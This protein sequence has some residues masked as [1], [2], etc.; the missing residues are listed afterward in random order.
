MKCSSCGAE[1]KE[2]AEFCVVCGKPLPKR[3]KC[4]KCGTEVLEGVMFCTN[5]GNRFEQKPEPDVYYEEEETSNPWKWVAVAL[6]A[7]LL[8]G[9]GAYWYFYMMPKNTSSDASTETADTTTQVISDAADANYAEAQEIEEDYEE[10]GDADVEEQEEEYDSD[11]ETPS[12]LESKQAD[13]PDPSNGEWW[14]GSI[15]KY[16]IRMYINEDTSDFWYEYTK[17]GNRLYLTV[18]E[19]NGDHLVLLETNKNGNETG[20]FD[21]YINGN[22]YSGTFYNLYNGKTFG[23]TL[24]KQ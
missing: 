16:G 7:L 10:E 1:I 2:G 14:A 6:V 17:W 5:C 24:K 12:L 19:N 4:P 20:K 3:K 22:T 18:V 23:F 15:G 8:I 13:A 11:S 21:G 9:G